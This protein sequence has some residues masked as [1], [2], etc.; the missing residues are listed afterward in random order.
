MSY[1]L[2]KINFCDKIFG[3][4]ADRT[5]TK[6][7]TTCQAIACGAQIDSKTTSKSR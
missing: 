2:A 6:N 4:T 1:H 3:A 5:C 7:K